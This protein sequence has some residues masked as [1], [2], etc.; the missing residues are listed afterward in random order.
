M[1]MIF[2]NLFREIVGVLNPSLQSMVSLNVEH[3]GL[4]S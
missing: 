4:R 1:L 3:L 2:E